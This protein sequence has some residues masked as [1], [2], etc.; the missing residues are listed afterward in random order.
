MKKLRITN[1][2]ATRHALKSEIT[3]SAESRYDHRLHAV[4]LVSH[5]L[6]CYRVGD[7]LGVNARTVQRWVNQFEARGLAALRGEKHCGRPRKLNAQQ[8]E[9]IRRDVVTDPRRLGYSHSLWDVK[10]L[11]HHLSNAYGIKLG[12]RQCYRILKCLSASC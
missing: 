2:G 1:V 7:W 11:R 8:W 6:D 9:A 3:R 10:L 12:T 5:G 4:L